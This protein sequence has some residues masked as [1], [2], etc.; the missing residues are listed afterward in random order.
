MNG[1][2]RFNGEIAVVLHNLWFFLH[3]KQLKVTSCRIRRSESRVF[4]Y[5]DNFLY[6]VRF[7]RASEA[8]WVTHPSSPD[9]KMISLAWKLHVFSVQVYSFL[10]ILISHT[11]DVITQSPP[12]SSV[13]QSDC[14]NLNS[15]VSQNFC[16]YIWNTISSTTWYAPFKSL[17][18]ASKFSGISIGCAY[19]WKKF[20]DSNPF[21]VQK[22]IDKRWKIMTLILEDFHFIIFAKTSDFRFVFV[23]QIVSWK[24]GFVIQIRKIHMYMS[25]NPIRNLFFWYLFTF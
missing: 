18:D 17:V 9:L 22:G 6:G 16:S 25:C 2:Y 8:L 12:I 19:F 20:K 4:E 15:D 11:S 13:V 24:H 10:Q 21:Y 7:I 1:Y 3:C 14:F 23:I 5:S